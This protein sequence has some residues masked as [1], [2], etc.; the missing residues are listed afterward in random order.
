MI[1]SV[2]VSIKDI[3]DPVRNLVEAGMDDDMIVSIIRQTFGIGYI[4]M[5]RRAILRVRAEKKNG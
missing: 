3:M 5:T 2:Q 1:S 4:G